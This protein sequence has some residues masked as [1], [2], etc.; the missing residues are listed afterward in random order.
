MKF[1]RKIGPKGENEVSLYT[2][3]IGEIRPFAIG[4]KKKAQDEA[5]AYIRALPGFVGVHPVPGMGT[6]LLFDTE[7]HA[8]DARLGLMSKGC[9]VGNNVTECYAPK[10]DL[11]PWV[12][13]GNKA[14]DTGNG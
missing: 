7:K 10:E 8:I 1:E 14:E 3:A 13:G 6:I 4:K 9:P 11:P 5:L 12:C 2:V